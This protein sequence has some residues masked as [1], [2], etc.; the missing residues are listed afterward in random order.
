[1]LNADDP[2]LSILP[3]IVDHLFIEIR[4]LLGKDC[5]KKLDLKEHPDRGVYIQGEALHKYLKY[6]SQLFSNL[7]F[8]KYGVLNFKDNSN[9]K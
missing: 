1:M 3:I 7:L 9:N 2:C 6:S 5:K 4:D 8:A